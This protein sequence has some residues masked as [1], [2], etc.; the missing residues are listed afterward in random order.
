MNFKKLLIIDDDPSICEL[1]T[2]VAKN[3]DY[4]VIATM[5]S[6]EFQKYYAEFKP[7][8]LMVDLQL[9]QSDTDGIQLL[10][11]LA[12]E[13]CKLPI[14][15]MTGFSEKILSA[16]LRLGQSH[17]LWMERTLQKP[18]RMIDVANILNSI[19]SPVQR[20]TPASIQKDLEAENFILHYQPKVFIKTQQLKAAEVMIRHKD[21]DYD[22][23]T[24]DSYLDAAEQAEMIK[25]FT[26]WMIE[27]AIKQLSIWHKNYD[28]SLAINVSAKVLDD[29]SFPDRLFDLIKENQ[30]LPTKI[31]LEI[32]ENIVMNK[33]K[34][35][36]DILVRL[37]LKG[38][39]LALD[40]FGMGSSSLVELY[41]MPFNEIKIDKSFIKNIDHDNEAQIITRAIIDLGHNL[42][43]AVVAEGVQTRKAWDILYK[44]NCDAAQGEFI[45]EPLQAENFQEMLQ[46]KKLRKIA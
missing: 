10:R 44:F 17:G 33:P 32:N 35:I 25:P 40:D 31:V 27:Q 20:L 39:T 9:H 8:V 5:S 12:D 26:W 29:L 34:I 30:I 22:T 4:E 14:I 24:N 1:I 16:A 11:Y 41:H 42:G 15:L 45:C 13:H 36:M 18:F 21:M 6:A 28:F 3:C 37:R 38:F 2:A 19:K 46:S 23:F 43:L 7:S